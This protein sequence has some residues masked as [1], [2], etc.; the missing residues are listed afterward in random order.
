ALVVADVHRVND[1]ARMPASDWNQ[2]ADDLVRGARAESD[3]TVAAARRDAS[4]IIDRANAEAMAVL[5]R[6]NA[7]AMALRRGAHDASS[8]AGSTARTE[9]AQV[10][11]QRTAIAASLTALQ[12]ALAHAVDSMGPRPGGPVPPDPSAP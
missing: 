3:A 7:E 11:R 4:A 1:A 6:A 5:D 9:L 2:V 8:L 10:E 12:Q